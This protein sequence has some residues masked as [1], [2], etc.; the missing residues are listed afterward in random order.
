M[1]YYF[2]SGL[3]LLLS[4]QLEYFY[5]KDFK[6]V[7]LVGGGGDAWRNQLYWQKFSSIIFDQEKL[8]YYTEIKPNETLNI[9]AFR[10]IMVAASFHLVSFLFILDVGKANCLSLVSH[11]LLLIH[12]INLQ[13]TL[14]IITL[15]KVIR[16]CATW[17]YS[18]TQQDQYVEFANYFCV[19]LELKLTSVSTL[20]NGLG[21][22]DK[23][24]L[25]E[26][27]KNE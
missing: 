15:N 14:F 4:S 11:L 9:T 19:S 20:L 16:L 21:R 12:P 10:N 17:Q 7:P 2:Y 8:H 5:L 24:K 6:P 3:L 23:S 13:A 26:N 25:K 18:F 22:N 1:G 27:N